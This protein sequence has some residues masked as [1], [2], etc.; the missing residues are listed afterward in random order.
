MIRWIKN[1]TSIQFAVNGS[2]STRSQEICGTITKDEDWNNVTVTS[3][4]R[5]QRTFFNPEG[6][7]HLYLHFDQSS[8]DAHQVKASEGNEVGIE[9][10]FTSYTG[11]E[12]NLTRSQI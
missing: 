9:I 2:V 11:L 4:P 1:N 6:G 8:I 7:L 3:D 10:V 12:I 5:R